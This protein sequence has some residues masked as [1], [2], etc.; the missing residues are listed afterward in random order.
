MGPISAQ[1]IVEESKNLRLDPIMDADM[2]WIVEEYCKAPLPEGW[3]RL[4][5]PN[6]PGHRTRYIHRRRR[7]DVTVSPILLRFKILVDHFKAC[8]AKETPVDEL[9]VMEL[10]APLE[11]V[12]DVKEMAEYLGIAPHKEPHLMWIAKLAVLEGVPEGWEEVPVPGPMGMTMYRRLADGRVQSEHPGDAIHKEQLRKERQKRPPKLTVHGSAHAKTMPRYHKERAPDGSLVRVSEAEVPDCGTYLEFYDAYGHRLWVDLVTERITADIKEVRRVP[13]ARAIQRMWRGYAMRKHLAQYHVAAT[14]IGRAYR[15]HLYRRALAEVTA[16]WDDA[17]AVLQYNWRIHRM[18]VEYGRL[19]FSRLIMKGGGLRNID[20]DKAGIRKCGCS[21]GGARMRVIL[22]QRCWRQFLQDRKLRAAGVP[23][24]RR[25]RALAVMPSRKQ[26][27]T[28]KLTE[29]VPDGSKQKP[30]I[31][32]ID[33]RTSGKEAKGSRLASGGGGAVPSRALSM[34][35]PLAAEDLLRPRPEGDAP[36]HAPQPSPEP[37]HHPFSVAAVPPSPPKP[38]LPQAKQPPPP[39]PLLHQLPSQMP[40]EAAASIMPHPGMPAF[41]GHAPPPL[42]PGSMPPP[43]PRVTPGAPSV[44]PAPSP[45]PPEPAGSNS[46]LLAPQPS[47]GQVPGPENKLPAL[48]APLP[49]LG[50]GPG[51]PFPRPP[52]NLMQFPPP[53]FTAPPFPG[54][55]PF[56]PG[57]MPLPPLPMGIPPPRQCQWP[58]HRQLSR[59]RSITFRRCLN[60]TSPSDRVRPTILR[61]PLLACARIQILLWMHGG[62]IQGRIHTDKS[63]WGHMQQGKPAGAHSNLMSQLH[64]GLLTRHRLRRLALRALP[65]VHQVG[66]SQG[67]LVRRWTGAPRRKKA[68]PLRSPKYAGNEGSSELVGISGLHV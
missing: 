27:S 19:L 21:F 1:T 63:A 39:L 48:L 64:R 20:A 33:R 10:L 38:Q 15:A 28:A 14:R 58:P 8:K 17:A 56:P 11:R 6:A 3:E 18:K 23:V 12:L 31:A 16:E 52:P 51:L 9:L 55:R 13:A 22:I 43:G 7:L 42:P 4:E 46:L 60:K 67:L 34:G 30:A 47:P 65:E 66:A 5:M 40:G 44:A 62:Q 61:Y 53:N 29:P 59:R 41:P 2:M 35:K 57:Q 54:P 45:S 26:S 32:A 37:A 25:E 68:G 49:P 50:A 24:V 36:A